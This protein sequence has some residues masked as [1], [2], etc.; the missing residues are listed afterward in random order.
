MG[1]LRLPDPFGPGIE[2]GSMNLAH[3]LWISFRFGERPSADRVLQ[4]GVNL[5]VWQR[6]LPAQVEDFAA[7]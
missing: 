7:W 4:D 6:R 1:W 5:A 3:R 2:E